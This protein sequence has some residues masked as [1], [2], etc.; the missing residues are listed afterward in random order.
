MKREHSKEVYSIDWGGT[1]DNQ[2][3]VTGSW[4]HSV[5]LVRSC[6]VMYDNV[7]SCTIM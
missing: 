3:I 1:R 4:D 5:K 2:C 7:R 6:R